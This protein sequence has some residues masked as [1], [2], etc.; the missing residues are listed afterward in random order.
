MKFKLKM[1]ATWKEYAQ[2]DVIE[3]DE[4]TAKSLKS[5]GLA[6]DYDEVAEET[7]KTKK[8][9][10]DTTVK[11]AVA[12]AVK[13][14]LKDIKGTAGISINYNPVIEVREEVPTF[15]SLGEQL[16]AVKDFVISGNMDPRLENIQKAAS[17]Y[18][19]TAG[20]Q[21]GFLVQEDFLDELSQ[22][23]YETGV[24]AS[25]VAVTEISANSNVLNYTEVL[26]YDRTDGNRPVSLTWLDEAAEKQ[27]SRASFLRRTLTLK[28]LAGI[29]Y[30]TDELLEDH[31]ALT[32]EVGSWFVREFGF[33]LDSAIYDGTGIGTPEGYMNSSAL[34][35]QGA[36][37]GQA[38]ETV[39]AENVLKMFSRMPSYLLGGA[40]WFINQQVFPQLM[41]MTLANQPVW[42]PPN[43]LV[44]APAGLLLGKPV[45][46]IEQADALGTAG[47][48]TFGNMSQ[49]KM[50]R[51]GGIKA[52]SSIHVRFIEDEVCFRFY[53]RADGHSSWS[54][55]LTP[56]NG[57]GSGSESTLSPFIV[58]E[59]R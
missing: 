44:G 9:E 24:L 37:A 43:G 58:L 23:T 50:I 11:S 31:A 36:E 7:A 59:D 12:E 46:I 26:D 38:A 16:Q 29:Y 13:A 3:T 22:R 27:A 30:A 54:D 18:N 14:S 41:A 55:T 32:S 15:K 1:L 17:G 19:E 6:E 2:G 5:L 25:K 34:V 8:A 4:A 47:D 10:L 45:N 52:A 49:Y 21:G 28:K 33:M 51:K 40:E 39:V 53:L 56:K 42:L 35:T 57:G 20:A 48:I